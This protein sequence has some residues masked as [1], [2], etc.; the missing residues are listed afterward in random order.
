MKKKI[1]AALLAM[2]MVFMQAAYLPDVFE[3]GGSAYAIEGE[4]EDY[5]YSTLEDGT[6]KLTYCDV[7]DGNV[8]IPA[9]IGGK[10]VSAL[11]KD[12][13]R[14]NK[15]IKAVTIP[16]SIK[17]IGAFAFSGCDALESVSMPY[18]LTDIGEKAFHGTKWI[19]KVT[20]A[21]GLA[22]VN[23]V[24][25]EA[26][27]TNAVSA[28]IPDGVKVVG[29][30]A[31]AEMTKLTDVSIPASVTALMDDAFRNCTALKSIVVPK[32]VTGLRYHALGYQYA[33]G[34][35]S[36]I[37][38]FRIFCYNGTG[39][40]NYSKWNSLDYL[41][42]DEVP[43]RIYGKDRFETAFGV[44][45]A[46]R[47]ANGGSKFKNV[48]IAS[49]MDF[50]DALSAAYL[51]K[52]KNAPIILTADFAL[53]RVAK[54]VK[55]NSDA[56][57]TVYII[58]G[59]AAVSSNTEKALGGLKTIRIAGPNRYLTNL[60]VLNEAGVSSEELLAVSGLD[61][62]DALSASAVGKPI[63]LVPT[64]SLLANQQSYLKTLTS[65]SAVIIGGTGAVSSSVQTQL[66]AAI[67]NVIRVGGADRYETSAKVAEKYFPNAQSVM[68]SYG[69]NYPDGLC[70]GPL[71]MKHSMPLLLC[72]GSSFIAAK[73]YAVKAMPTKAVVL[74]GQTL[75]TD[76]AVRA[77]L[78]TGITAT[79]TTS[80]IS[81]NWKS[82]YGAQKYD[83]LEV[84]GS[85]RRLGTVSGTSF[86]YTLGSAQ[87]QK[88]EVIPLKA[89]SSAITESIMFI[90]TGTDPAAVSGLRA[91]SVSSSTAQITW[92]DT[93]HTSYQV[94]RKIN[95]TFTLVGTTSSNR[96]TDTSLKDDSNYEYMVRCM[97]ADGSGEKHYGACS[98]VIK[99]KTVP[100]TPVFTEC[101]S[102]FNS[103]TLRWVK[104]S[105]I[106]TYYASICKNGT[107]YTYSTTNNYYV[108]SNLTRST[109]YQFR[110]YGVKT[111]SGT[112]YNTNTASCT[113]ATDSTVKS[114][115]A[116]KIYASPSTSAQ[117]VYSGGAGIVLTRK[118][119]YSTSWYKVYLPGTTS[120]SFG[121]VPASQVAGYVNLNFS[122]IAQLGWAGG[123]PMPT[124]CETT[125]LATLL[126]CHLG[127]PCTKNLLAD[128]FLTIVGYVVGDPHYA[129][130]GSPYDSNAY[131][132]MSPALAETA[133]RFL[134]SIGVRDQYQIDVH[135]D[136]D[137]NMSWHKLD[138]GTITHTTGLDLA[139]LKS[140]LEKGHA[141]QIWWITRGADPDSYVT[142]NIQRGQRY[143]HDGTGTYKFTWVGTQHGSVLSGYDETTGNFII[144]DVGWG[145]TV[146]HSMSHFMKIYTAQGRQ[147]IVIY[148]K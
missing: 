84:T 71:A 121:Y 93:S 137:P 15:I 144:A 81:L 31:F 9:Q 49:G 113:L 122:P 43:E 143:S 36:K 96:F 136:N 35:Y 73:N 114:K 66:G 45:D 58:G 97:F 52:V 100:A 126:A 51:A 116:F 99:L 86:T 104:S 17:K 141:V 41:L 74:G 6:L 70:G 135:L 8:V 57:A 107:W 115:T 128:S 83:I 94:Y 103:I 22:V 140:E 50:A 44:A 47:C 78:S 29:E 11:G 75:V 34:V 127:L 125:A 85:K 53:D 46:M 130:W 105:D 10:T 23:G 64:N 24:L 7:Q 145:Y 88:I 4:L 63:L 25:I 108:F 131:G 20:A 142:F 82:V 101:S 56:N 146:Y 33:S 129:S 5:S 21:D 91:V 16:D 95:G 60:L 69:I 109:S 79:H 92:N 1:L 89:D 119:V 98:S 40:Q 55:A 147:S 134:K 37:D 124:G 112:K 3:Q 132:V 42:I 118:G 76:E 2:G 139:G 48:I 106:T 67:A 13:F 123:K 38:G 14:D 54:Y 27:D 133:N 90:V 87:T 110:L 102:G 68:L 65:K 77:I 28:A 30:G 32:T 61:Y 39:A 117:V 19:D 80:S 59:N 148:K 120:G 26:A 18:A 111:V 138:T 72:T 62:A 12:L